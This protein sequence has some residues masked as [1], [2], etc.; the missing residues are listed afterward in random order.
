[1]DIAS[2]L[3]PSSSAS[4]PAGYHS[5]LDQHLAH[6]DLFTR[7]QSSRNSTLSPNSSPN[8]FKCWHEQ[9]I[10]YVY[11][12]SNQQDRDNHVRVHSSSP[13]RD[14]E[15]RMATASSSRPV[16][17]L[18]LKPNP[19]TSQGRLPPIQPPA[20]LVTTNLPSL[21]FPTPSTGK[22]DSVPSF[23]IPEGKPP[24]RQG[25]VEN[26]VDPQ[27]PPLKRTR[28]GHHRLQSI[29]ELNLLR[30]DGS[31]LRCR[32]SNRKVRVS[33]NFVFL[34]P[35]LIHQL[36][37]CPPNMLVLYQCIAVRKRMA[38]ECLGLLSRIHHLFN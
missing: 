24:I 20:T 5:W 37:R 35:W 28:L 14:A 16:E 30:N 13:P 2:I 25:S 34:G 7:P 29:G 38:L 15:L 33:P 26:S 23:T 9:C 19:F 11:G 10:H 32:A 21:P 36:V 12:F 31:C 22:R 18:V 8:L 1:M 17:Q 4:T 27:L 3:T 6:N